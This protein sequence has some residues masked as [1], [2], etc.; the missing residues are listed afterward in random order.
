MTTAAV[1]EFPLTRVRWAPPKFPPPDEWWDRFGLFAGCMC[2][3]AAGHVALL[4]L[5][6]WGVNGFHL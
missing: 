1:F 2:I 6:Q 5:I 3:S 4:A